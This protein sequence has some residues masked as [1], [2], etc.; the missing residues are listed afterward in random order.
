MKTYNLLR[1]LGLLVFIF[2]ILSAFLKILSLMY[3]KIVLNLPFKNQILTGIELL[4]NGVFLITL[5][6]LVILLLLIIIELC[7]RISNDSLL[8]LPK[9]IIA[10]S[11]F[12]HFLK[13]HKIVDRWENELYSQ[14]Q[15]RIIASFNHAVDKSVID[16]TRKELRLFIQIPKEAQSTEILNKQR[17]L[18]KQHIFSFYSEYIISDFKEEKFSLWIVGTKK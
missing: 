15:S 12:R 16:L 1:N 17:I 5:L 4:Y 8:N 18:I 3:L 13:Q 7:K 10:T 9:S 14:S 11:R 2:A 6:G